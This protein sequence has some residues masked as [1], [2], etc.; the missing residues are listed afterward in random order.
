MAPHGAY[1]LKVWF[2]P[3]VL[4][5]ERHWRC[6]LEEHGKIPAPSLLLLLLSHYEKFFPSYMFPQQCY[7]LIMDPKVIGQLTMAWNCKDMIPGAASSQFILCSVGTGAD[8]STEGYWDDF[9]LLLIGCCEHSL[10]HLCGRHIFISFGGSI[11][12]C[13]CWVIWCM[14]F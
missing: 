2:Q 7:Y 11:Q 3:M 5:G 12:E 1:A 9:Y 14:H 6:I 8:L 4:L 10:I 13:S